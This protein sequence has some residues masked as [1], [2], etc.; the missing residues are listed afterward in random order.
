[1]RGGVDERKRT[2]RGNP[3][4]PNRDHLTVGVDLGNIVILNPEGQS[5]LYRD[6]E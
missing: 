2:R 5:S 3:V 4:G 6:E 1:M